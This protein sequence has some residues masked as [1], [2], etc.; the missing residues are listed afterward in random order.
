VRLTEEERAMLA[1]EHGPAVAKAMKILST[2]GEIYGAD[3]MISVSSVQVAG[4]SYAN[5]GEAGLTFL[6][7][8]AEDGARVVV[9]TMLNPAGMDLVNWQRLGIPEE[10]AAKQRAVIG[11]YIAMG[12]RPTCTCVPYL[13]GR[14]PAYG[15]HL[16]W[17]ESS[18]VSYA[19]SMLG[20]RTNREGGPSALAAAIAGRTPRYGLH[21][22]K[23]RV[24]HYLIEVRC[25][26][27][28]MADYG[29][30][31]YM[32]GCQVRGGVPYFRFKEN[33]HGLDSARLVLRALGAAMAA[34]GAVA[35]YHVEGITPEARRMNIIAP[36]VQ[37]LI[38]DD[39]S[40]GYTALNDPVEEIDL[41]SVGC[42]HAAL[43]EIEAVAERL[44][45]L[46]VRTTLWVTTARQ[47]LEEAKRLDLLKCIEEAGGQVVADTCPVVAPVRALGIRTIATNS[48]KLAFYSRS[49][50]GLGVRF[51]SLDR[52]VEAA[53]T[54]RWE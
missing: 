30:L 54:G 11:A 45:G 44:A 1:G 15:E 27:R 25:A 7:N 21:I 49:Y 6:R 17:S 5:I 24:A 42:P 53:I 43:E 34:S 38:I 33:C 51:G 8:W 50:N 12:I 22:T 26:L 2:L 36:D 4:V 20:A 46:H 16:A 29:A 18:A 14:K 35:L 13:V 39:L 23:N 3:R 28:S 37:R 41:V 10:F 31:G 32:V 19:N 52:C 9:P 47:I 48:A 40:A